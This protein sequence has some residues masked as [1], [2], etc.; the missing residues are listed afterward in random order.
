MATTKFKDVTVETTGNLPAVGSIAPNFTLVDRKFA[1]RSLS[2]FRGKHV[3]L[4]IFPTIDT[5]VCSASVR[6]F[7][8]EIAGRDDAVVLCISA[9]LPLSFNRFCAAEGIDNVE[10]LSVFR[11]PEFGDVYGMRMLNGGFTGLLA[12]SVVVLDPKGKVV[13]TELVPAIGQ[14][15]NYEAAMAAVS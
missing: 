11:N 2:E 8:Q 10:V 7:N 12:R 6:R 3:V 14:E 1:D 5:G 9:D 4:S 13:Y 15:P